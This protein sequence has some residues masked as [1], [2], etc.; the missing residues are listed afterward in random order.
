LLEALSIIH[1][2]C[3]GCATKGGKRDFSGIVAHY[4]DKHGDLTDLP[5]AQPQLAGSQW[6]GHGL[7]DMK[8]AASVQH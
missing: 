8:K 3:D 5:V 1:I 4:V 2:S 7:G 6:Q